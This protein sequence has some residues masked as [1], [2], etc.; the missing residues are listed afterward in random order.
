MGVFLGNKKYNS[1]ATRETRCLTLNISFPKK[2][3]KKDTL[4]KVQTIL[5]LKFEHSWKSSKYVF[6]KSI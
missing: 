4:I 2:T 6:G 5:T 3:S 1:L